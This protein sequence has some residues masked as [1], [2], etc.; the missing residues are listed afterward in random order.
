MRKHD[1]NSLSEINTFEGYDN[2]TKP[3]FSNIIIKA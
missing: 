1:K 2:T 3:I